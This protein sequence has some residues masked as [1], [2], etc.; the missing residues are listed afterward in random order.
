MATEPG[1]PTAGVD[2]AAMAERVAERLAEVRER[3]ARAGGGP[4][5]ITVVAVTK[6]FGPDAVVAATSAGIWDVGEN[7]AQDLL[8]KAPLAPAG[9]RWHFLGEPQRNKLARLAPVV[10]LWQ[11]LD[12]EARARAL[13]QRC[14]GAAVLVE[15]RVVDEPGR[16]GV[17]MDE[18]PG[19]V[20]VATGQGLEVRGLMAVGPAGD[21]PAARRCFRTVAVMASKLGLAVVSMGMSAD[22]EIAVA[23]G[24]TMVRLGRALFGPRPPV[25][26]P[27]VG[28]GKLR[29]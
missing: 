6:G 22:Y 28:A 18:V 7:Y 16:H 5:H 17:A 9:A 10:H 2:P 27:G 12:S 1:A 25:H 29:W 24:A 11:A 21:A 13:A 26:N 19:L 4:E 23:E 15:V 20:E 14:P 3:I 8:A